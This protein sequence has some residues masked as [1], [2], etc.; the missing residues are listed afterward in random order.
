M[1][2]HLCKSLVEQEKVGVVSRVGTMAS[3]CWAATWGLVRGNFT[4]ARVALLTLVAVNILAYFG[5]GFAIEFSFFEASQVYESS[6][7]SRWIDVL[8]HLLFFAPIL[9][10][11]NL[12]LLGTCGLVLAVAS[13]MVPYYMQ[14]TGCA[15]LPAT[16]R[17][18]L[19]SGSSFLLYWW[20]MRKDA[21]NF[22]AA[23]SR[24]AHEAHLSA[25]GRKKASAA[26]SDL[27]AR[28]SSSG[29]LTWG[30][31]TCSPA[32][33]SQQTPQSLRP[34]LYHTNL[35]RT[36]VQIQLDI[37]VDPDD[38]PSITALMQM[39]AARLPSGWVADAAVRH[40]CVLVSVEVAVPVEV[41]NLAEGPADRVSSSTLSSAE[42]SAE[43]SDSVRSS[44]V[45][46]A[47]TM[48]SRM[49]PKTQELTPKLLLQVDDHKEVWLLDRHQREWCPGPDP[50]PLPPPGMFQLCMP[51]LALTW[52]QQA[53]QQQQQSVQWRAASQQPAAAGAACV[54]HPVRFEA[55]VHAPLSA[56]QHGL[57]GWRG[58]PALD[59]PAWAAGKPVVLV[60][61][62]WGKY[63]PVQLEALHIETLGSDAGH[64]TAQGSAFAQTAASAQQPRAVCRFQVCVSIP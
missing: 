18:L 10:I 53:P 45:D 2:T 43:L 37:D 39:L 5:I 51:R 42:L 14:T 22:R 27:E 8:L 9:V 55:C 60:R 11:A 50:A 15:C 61:E 32:N 33:S 21:A 44:A 54:V 59:D 36:R 48:L 64:Q 25:L 57:H 56:V 28:T 13:G 38:L 7:S 20:I 31:V 62:A 63:L 23:C 16:M 41:A 3:T 1:T 12:P 46:W 29:R 40:G 47:S 49:D 24:A 58:T 26:G 4:M 30:G 52:P 6:I 34:S 19:V 35:R 17:A